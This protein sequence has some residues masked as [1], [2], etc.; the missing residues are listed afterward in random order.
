MLFSRNKKFFSKK[1]KKA[2]HQY[3]VAKQLSFLRKKGVL[4]LCS[5]NIVHNLGQLKFPE[6]STYE[7]AIEFD[8]ISK[9]MKIYFLLPRTVNTTYS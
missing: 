4:I 6:N 5:G 7:W 9:K 1:A 2:S 3:E 8:E